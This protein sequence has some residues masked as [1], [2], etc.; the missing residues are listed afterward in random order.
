MVAALTTDHAKDVT[1]PRR[2]SPADDAAERDL[3]ATVAET[4]ERIT[5]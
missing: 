1:E 4:P 2:G 5:A 3:P